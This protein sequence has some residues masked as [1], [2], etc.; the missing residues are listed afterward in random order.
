MINIVYAS[1]TGNSEAIA[2]RISKD[3]KSRKIDNTLDSMNRFLPKIEKN[4]KAQKLIL[5]I[6]CSTTGNGDMPENSEKFFRFIKKKTHPSDY[7]SNV[8]YTILGLGD[9]NYSKFQFIPKQVD[10]ILHKLGAKK[11]YKRGEADEASGL[12]NIVEPWIDNLFPLITKL[13]S[14]L[15][16]NTDLEQK[17]DKYIDVVK[18]RE[19]RDCSIKIIDKQLISGEYSNQEIYKLRLQL[20]DQDERVIINYGCGSHIKILGKNNNIKIN[21]I[22]QTLLII[23]KELDNQTLIS[24][25]ESYPHFE[26]FKAKPILNYIDIFEFMIDFSGTPKKIYLEKILSLTFKNTFNYSL[27]E[28]LINN[29]QKIVLENKI[30]ISE[31]ISLLNPFEISLSNILSCFP[32][33]YPRSYSIASN[34]NTDK[35]ILEIIFSYSEHNIKRRISDNYNFQKEVILKGFCTSYLKKCPINE[36]LIFSG[37]KNFFPFPSEIISQQIPLLYI[38]NGTGITPFISYLKE[39]KFLISNKQNVSVPEIRI[40]TGFRS[41][42]KDKNETIEEDKILEMI[43]EINLYQGKEKIKY[44]RC[45]SHQSGIVLI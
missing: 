22:L 30:N 25:Y 5:I 28:D 10:D 34:C 38:C 35:N 12:E 7:L 44:F 9:S 1:Q 45:L 21:N 27:I 42:D 24:F 13:Q 39:L 17:N 33:L 41:D 29:Y 14:E 40:L 8:I 15:N 18:T 3:L 26:Y 6:V 11:F 31:I 32:I 19:K 23:E 20:N 36:E 2:K 43:K 4:D 37:I 16:S